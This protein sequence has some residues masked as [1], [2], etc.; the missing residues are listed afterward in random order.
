VWKGPLLM[1]HLWWK[2]WGSSL[3]ILSLRGLTL[4]RESSL[5]PNLTPTL[6]ALSLSPDLTLNLTLSALPEP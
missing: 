5:S 1:P 2:S 6:D 3:C 4:T